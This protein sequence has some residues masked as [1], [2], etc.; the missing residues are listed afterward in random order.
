MK[1]LH[2]IGLTLA[3]SGCS[4][5]AEDQKRVASDEARPQKAS[6]LLYVS[7]EQSGDISI[8]DP[9]S[10][11]QIGRIAIGKR[12]R[13]LVASPDGKLL[14]VAVSGSPIA[15]PGVDESTL[16]PAD[17]GA[18][19]IVVIDLASRKPLRTL[20]GISDPEQIAV[21]PDGERLYVA[22]EDTGQLIVISKDGKLIA[23]LAVGGEPEGVAVSPDGEIVL[24][25][26]EED[27]SLAIVRGG[28]KPRVAQRVIVGERPR[29][30]IFLSG[31]RVLVPGEMDASLSIVDV[32]QARILRT[33]KFAAEDRPMGVAIHPDGSLFL[34]TGRGGRL[35]HV[36]PRDEA[37]TKPLLGAVVVGSRPWG[38]ALAPDGDFAFTANGPDNYVSIVE[39]RTMRLL[40]RV[41]VGKAPWGVVAIPVPASGARR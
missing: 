14:Y 40:T 30:V 24:A 8:V 3:L 17:K 35:L 27:H 41:K 13:G 26:S 38:V 36:D 19:G 25:T 4:P 18:D 5:S 33:I 39:I 37:A 16:P 9:E 22:S 20:R 1:H 34:T 28:D 12:P 21:S 29:N 7:N 10:R 11:L 6:Y 15:G 32:G 23:K 2:L 31:E